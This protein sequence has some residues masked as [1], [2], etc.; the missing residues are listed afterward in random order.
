MKDLRP[1]ICQAHRG[2]MSQQLAS[3]KGG[4]ELRED[5]Q[6]LPCS[7][8]TNW[9]LPTPTTAVQGPH[10]HPRSPLHGRPPQ[11]LRVLSEITEPTGHTSSVTVQN[12]VCD[13]RPRADTLVAH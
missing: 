9:V 8:G 11:G 3:T 4:R 5:G 1:R 12:V 13:L 7:E 2:E 6:Q 10:P